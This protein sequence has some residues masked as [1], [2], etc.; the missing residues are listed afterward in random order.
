MTQSGGTNDGITARI[1]QVV[2]AENSDPD[3]L[4]VQYTKTEG[5]G[6][7]TNT[8]PIR[9]NAGA[10]LTVV[11]DDGNNTAGAN[12]TVQSVDTT[13]NPAVGRGCLIANGSGDFFAR[14]HFVFVKEQKILLSKYTR[15]PTKVV[16]F[17][18]TEDI[19]TSAD[20]TALFDNQGAVP[21]L[22]SPGADRYRIQLTLTTKDQIQAGENFVYYCDVVD[23]NIVD[24]VK[25]TDDYNKIN[26]LLAQRTFDESGNYIVKNFDADYSDS[27]TN[28][29]ASIGDGVAYVNGYRGATEKPTKL[30]IPKPRTTVTNT[31][32]N[33]GIGYGQYINVEGG[34]DIS[35]DLSDNSFEQ[36]VLVDSSGTNAKLGGSG[37]GGKIA[38]A[39]L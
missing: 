6:T 36:L 19:V 4:Y 16:G 28:F 5:S 11:L 30:T 33:I 22:S 20:D 26:E 39:R 37:N 27:G 29:I 2:T 12:L 3:T 8:N 18:I 35:G 23:G 21:N 15:F 10:T 1:L 17:K 14:G 7:Q 25:G 32:E 38:T 24:Q 9:F 34:A 31:N 13:A